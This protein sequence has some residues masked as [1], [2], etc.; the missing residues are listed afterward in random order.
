MIEANPF[1]VWG[2]TDI[3]QPSQRHEAESVNAW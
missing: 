3:G 2:A 1:T